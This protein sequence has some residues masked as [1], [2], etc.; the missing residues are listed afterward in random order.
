MKTKR[1]EMITKLISTES[2][3]TQEVLAELLSAHG[4]AVT[5]ATVSRDIKELHLV[6]VL[7]SNGTYKYSTM[8]KAEN[9]LQERFIR[10]FS[11]CVMSIIPCGNLIVIKTISGSASVAAEAIDNMQW[12]EIAGCIAGD[13]TVFIAVREGGSTQDLIRKLQ[14]MAAR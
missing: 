11:N 9:D 12:Q 5:Q 13:N 7:T 8:E 4:F 2:I 10:L 6:K 1:Q 3:E 14:K